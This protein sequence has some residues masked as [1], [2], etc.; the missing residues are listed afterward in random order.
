MGAGAGDPALLA[1]WKVELK[2]MADRIIDMR[3]ALLKELTK[4]QVPGDW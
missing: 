1:E 4:Q 3:V 2:G